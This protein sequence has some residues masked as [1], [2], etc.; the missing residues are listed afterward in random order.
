M[1][2]KKNIFYNSLLSI[3]N[4]IVPLLVFPYI[5]RVLGVDNFG[6]YS[7]V[8]GVI[9]FVI[10]FAMMGISSLGVREIA[11]NSNDES[12]LSVV[13]S[14]L[15]FLNMIFTI[16]V[17]IVFSVLVFVIPEF[18]SNKE[19]FFIGGIK[20]LFNLF[21]VEWF[22]VGIG[23]FS[24]ITIRTITVRLFYI[25]SIF[26]FVKT[27]EDYKL[28]YLL[29]VL[30][31]I[32]NAIFNW[33]FVRKQVSLSYKNVQL[34]LFF[35][36]FVL[37]GIYYI[38]TAIYSSFN[39]IYLGLISGQREV[40]YFSV[41]TK[42]QGIFLLIFT[43]FS[44]VLMPHMAKLFT[45]N[46]TSQMQIVIDKSS[47]LLYSFCIPIVIGAIVLA[48]QIIYITSGS[49]YEG[50]VL[51]MRIIMPTIL[52]IG[53]AQI[54]VFQVLIPL[55]LDKIILVNAIVGAIIGVILNLSLVSRFYSVG[56]SIVWLTSELIVLLLANY[57]VKKK[58]GIYVLNR[59]LFFHLF[60]SIPYIVICM[61][62]INY[63]NSPIIVLVSCFF[64]CF[65]YFLFLQFKIFKTPLI[66]A[67]FNNI[68]CKLKNIN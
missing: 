67:T 13:F 50:S 56:S 44:T 7:F 26:L 20:I 62:V 1:A 59:S 29:T 60:Y 9:S 8:D 17:L 41:A 21:L 11:Q 46:D 38:F 3:S 15:F 58:A 53:I 64:L 49:G 37:L 34:R 24:Y 18:V 25:A 55:K 48:P 5:S 47:Q 51:P 54:L 16:L 28:Y 2:L 39:I 43:A 12:K 65:M 66:I 6:I 22:F 19:M 32:I 57:F 27:K 31:I 42:I 23:K 4:Y 35:K 10:L 45:Q 36:P 33:I 61:I 63:F 52:I 14:S 40:G 30:T 68:T